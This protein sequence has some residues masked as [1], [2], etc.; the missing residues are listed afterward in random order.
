MK[1][2]CREELNFLYFSRNINSG[3]GMQVKEWAEALLSLIEKHD[4]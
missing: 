3:K 4:K 2:Q 1:T